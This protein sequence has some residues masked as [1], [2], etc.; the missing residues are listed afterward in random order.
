M[1]MPIEIRRSNYIVVGWIARCL[2]A[3]CLSLLSSCGNLPSSWKQ[4]TTPTREE[5]ICARPRESSSPA[6]RPR[7]EGELKPE[8]IQAV[9]RSR[10]ADFRGCYTELMAR[11]GA[12]VQG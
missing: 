12:S 2:P 7:G 10:Y 1:T 5:L 4:A 9:V 8:K 6:P 3:F 11:V